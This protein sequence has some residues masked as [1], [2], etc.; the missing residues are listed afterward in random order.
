MKNIDYIIDFAAHVGQEMLACGANL[1]RVNIT[2]EMICRHYNVQDLG[3]HSLS[4]MITVSGSD[5]D[6]NTRSNT[7]R[8]LSSS[9]NMERLKE[10]HKLG[11]TVVRDNPEPSELPQLLETALS[12]IKTHNI[13]IVLGAFEIAMIALARLFGGGYQELICVAVIRPGYSS[14][15]RHSQEFTLTR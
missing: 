10:L 7:V 13:W 1:E 14:C 2:I 9:L 8:V 6:G 11:R 12:G 15:Q 3:I 5:T 4:T